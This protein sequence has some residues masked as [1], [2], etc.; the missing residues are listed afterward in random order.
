MTPLHCAESS[1]PLESVHCPQLQLPRREASYHGEPVPAAS[2]LPALRRPA[3][4][5]L[6]VTDTSHVYPGTLLL[7]GP[8]SCHPCNVHGIFLRSRL[9]DPDVVC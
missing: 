5:A 9:G 4:H 8:M 7:K 2:S 1:A 6:A 3:G